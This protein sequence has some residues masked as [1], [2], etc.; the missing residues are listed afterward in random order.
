VFEEDSAEENSAKQMLREPGE[1][2]LTGT[3][4]R[5]FLYTIGQSR[6]ALVSMQKW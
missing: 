6:F 1:K 4:H 3:R 5:K 2:I